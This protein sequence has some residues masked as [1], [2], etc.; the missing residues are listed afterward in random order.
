MFITGVHLQ[1][2]KISFGGAVEGRLLT[3][4]T[5]WPPLRTVLAYPFLNP[6]S[7]TVCGR[8]WLPKMPEIAFGTR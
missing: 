2:S 1:S 6:N 3:G 7:C 8:L 4:R 5:L